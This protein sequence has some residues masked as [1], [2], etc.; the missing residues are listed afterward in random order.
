MSVGEKAS[1][2]IKTVS[3]DEVTNLLANTLAHLLSLL[4]KL[5]VFLLSR[6]LSL[7]EGEKSLALLLLELGAFLRR[8]PFGATN[9]GCT[10]ME[11]RV[12]S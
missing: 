3:S 7:L 2:G 11:S 10:Q 1:C 8:W 5:S 4:L 9:I 6:L 12:G